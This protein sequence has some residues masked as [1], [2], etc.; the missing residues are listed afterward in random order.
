MVG[1]LTEEV[2]VLTEVGASEAVE[3]SAE[4]VEEAASTDS[5]TTVLRSELW[6]R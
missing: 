5:R 2:E 3:D 6:V 4:V 1:V